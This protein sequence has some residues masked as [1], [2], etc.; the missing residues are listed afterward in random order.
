MA[1]CVLCGLSAIACGQKGPPL[2]PIVLVPR[3]VT[4]LTAKS[5]EIDVVIQ[6]T[7][8]NVNTDSSGPADLQSLEVYAHTGPL[9]APADFLKY[10]T[11]V[12]AIE[13]RNP[14]EQRAES[15]EQEPVPPKQ[16]GDVGEQADA[17]EQGATISVREPLT[18]AHKEIGPMPPTRPL[19]EAPAGTPVVIERLETPGTVNFELPPQRYYTVV[20]VSLSRN[21]R[22]PYAGPLQV[23]LAE[24]PAAPEKVDAS[25]TASAVSLTWPRLPE[26]VTPPLAGEK[27]APAVVERVS[28]ETHGTIEPFS[29]VETEDTQEPWRGAAAPAGKPQPPPR[30]RFGY[31]VYEV[32]PT[33]AAPSAPNAPV[34]PNAPNAPIAPV[35][36]L[37]TALLTAPGFTDPRVEFGT[38]RCYAVRRVEMTGAVAIEG[39]ATAPICVTPVDTFPPVAPKGLV[40]IAN[41]TGVSLLWEA[42]TEADLAG[43]VVLR[44]EAPGDTLSP[45]TPA[46]ITET[47]FTDATVRRGRTYVYEVVA[48]DKAEP[49]NQSPP[50]NRVEETIR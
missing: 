42:N 7:V 19:V 35:S 15:G 36:P 23:P 9:P 47:S 25:Y 32:D 18:D 1:L 50:S 37:N 40:H 46:P 13:V 4:G 30:P 31:N 8:P 26:D 14:K 11:L 10:G 29:D 34:S 38:R 33:V 5:V 17:V 27:P 44:G 6:F 39:A 21:R 45:L 24:P 2:A 48:V 22:G 3:A 41:A 12:A 20:G 49:G 28:Q 43:Y 16:N